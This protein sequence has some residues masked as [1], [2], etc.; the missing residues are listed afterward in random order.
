MSDDGESLALLRGAGS[1][2]AG[3]LCPPS[4]S[5]VSHSVHGAR[6]KK[7][8]EAASSGGAMRYEEDGIEVV[9]QRDRMSHE[10]RGALLFPSTQDLRPTPNTPEH[11]TWRWTTFALVWSSSILNPGR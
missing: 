10:A 7:P 11:R 4:T 9:M 5:A 2:V 8:H 6:P 1:S 3:S